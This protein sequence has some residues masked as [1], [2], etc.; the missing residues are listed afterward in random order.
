MTC[1]EFERGITAAVAAEGSMTA[2]M[3][4][5]EALKLVLGEEALPVVPAAAKTEG[6]ILQKMSRKQ[7]LTAD[8][9]RE[10]ETVAEKT[11]ENVE[12]VAESTLQ[13]GAETVIRNQQ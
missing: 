8:N 9:C 1:C 2:L 12:A 5:E 6:S 11:A 10:A 13:N 4:G 3:L 7:K